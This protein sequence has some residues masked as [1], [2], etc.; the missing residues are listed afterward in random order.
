MYLYWLLATV[1]GDSE[2]YM[3][4]AEQHWRLCRWLSCLFP[5]VSQ[6]MHA[7]RLGGSAAEVSRRQRRNFLWHGPPCGGCWLTEPPSEGHRPLPPLIEL[8]TSFARTCAW[9]QEG[10]ACLCHLAFV[11]I[12]GRCTM[13]EP[14][15]AFLST[16]MQ[17]NPAGGQ[18]AALCLTCRAHEIYCVFGRR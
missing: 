10:D 13:S 17:S 1:S 7:C 12:R 11:M 14:A 16:L 2:L 8:E 6:L 4:P 3:L 5:V 15:R 18:R 9:L